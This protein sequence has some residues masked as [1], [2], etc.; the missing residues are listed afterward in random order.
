LF[1]AQGRRLDAQIHF[2][3]AL[4]LASAKGDR[5]LANAIRQRLEALP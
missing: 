2:R 4:E 1:A 5:A 3:R